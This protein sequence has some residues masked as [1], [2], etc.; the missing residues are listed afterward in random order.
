MTGRA[1]PPD[2]CWN[3]KPVSSPRSTSICA[4]CRFGLIAFDVEVA[5]LQLIAAVTITV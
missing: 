3:W 2:G 4:G 1:A 5:L